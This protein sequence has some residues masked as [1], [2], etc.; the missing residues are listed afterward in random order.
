MC[1]LN[2]W[3]RLF[4]IAATDNIDANPNSDTVMSSLYD[5]ATSINQHINETCRNS[6]EI[7]N[8]TSNEVIIKKLP[9]RY[10]NDKPAYLPVK[11]SIMKPASIDLGYD[12]ES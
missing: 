5:I 2:L 6:C 1:A 10:T 9:H 11:V 3:F 12:Q 4:T 8:N 7:Q